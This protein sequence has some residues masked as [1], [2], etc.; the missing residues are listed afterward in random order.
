MPPIPPDQH[1]LRYADLK[2]RGI[3]NNRVTLKNW[4]EKLG[5]P[6]GRMIGPNTRT[7]TEAEVTDW[8]NK[9]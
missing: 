5:F 7:W 4:I 8:L 2:V 3:V 6:P 9:I 1:H